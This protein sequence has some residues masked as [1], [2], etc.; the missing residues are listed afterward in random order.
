VNLGS[1]SLDSGDVDNVLFASF[2]VG[3][4]IPNEGAINFNM[5]TTDNLYENTAGWPEDL[6]FD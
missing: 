6:G 2:R 1:S 3:I 5:T 4:A